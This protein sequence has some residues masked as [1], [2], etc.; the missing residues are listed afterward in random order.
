MFQSNVRL[1]ALAQLELA[2]RPDTILVLIVAA[3]NEITVLLP[4]AE[5]GAAVLFQTDA[6]QATQTQQH[7]QLRQRFWSLS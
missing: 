4:L 3:N 7:T 2:F 6:S 5:I 1:A